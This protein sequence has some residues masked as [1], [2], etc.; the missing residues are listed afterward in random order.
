M[1]SLQPP[2]TPVCDDRSS[3]NTLPRGSQ[4][5]GGLLTSR[6]RRSGCCSASNEHK[7]PTLSHPT[8]G[9]VPQGE[10]CSGESAI[11]EKNNLPSETVLKGWLRF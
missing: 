1:R 4:R 7:T 11:K 8:P 3:K 5:L 6:R 10:T 2:P 9:S